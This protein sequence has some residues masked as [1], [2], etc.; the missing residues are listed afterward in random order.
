VT[1]HDTNDEER[2][3]AYLLGHLDAEEQAQIE[4]RY[5]SDPGFHDELEA[6]ERDLIDRYVRGE[7]SDPEP[8]EKRYLSSPRRLQRVEFAR[9]LMQSLDAATANAGSAAARK[10]PV[11]RT[12]ASRDGRTWSSPPAARPL[13]I[14]RLPKLSLRTWLP[15][16][17]AAA[18]LLAAWALASWPAP[19]GSD[20]NRDE[21]PRQASGEPPAG[22]PPAP[23][24]RPPEPPAAARSNPVVTL[25]I[26]P[27]LTRESGATPT[28]VVD[29]DVIPELRLVVEPAGY[30][31]Y[32]TVLRT[33]DGTEVW[34]ADALRPESTAS[35]EAL[36]ITLPA[37]LLRDDDYIIMLTGVTA[38]GELE[39]AGGY[40]FRAQ[41]R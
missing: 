27:N 4:E 17:A 1:Q 29:R 20:Q 21:T 8:F 5:L 30:Q 41:L 7:L 34:R 13:V 19:D 10:P 9:T 15:A 14:G 37:G 22:T 23:E 12:L 24:P 32:R 33:A 18:V 25:V 26:L 35:G 38:G 28:L 2:L 39:A 40:Y 11:E 31:T 36:V 16:A 6:V 3:I